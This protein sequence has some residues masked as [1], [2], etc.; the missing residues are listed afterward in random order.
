MAYGAPWARLQ[1]MSFWAIFESMTDVLFAVSRAT[2]MFA[3]ALFAAVGCGPKDTRVRRLPASGTVLY[4]GEPVADAEV[5]FDSGG[6]SPAAAGKTDASGRFQLTTFDTNDG[7][8]PGDYKVAVRKVQVIRKAPAPA[9]DDA[10]GP[11][12]DEKWLLPMKYGN[13]ATSGFTATVNETGENDFK[14]ELVE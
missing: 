8:V 14:F 6:S 4:K 9:A 12:P 5:V 1:A 11:P 3:I 7:A 13:S 2:V 10:V